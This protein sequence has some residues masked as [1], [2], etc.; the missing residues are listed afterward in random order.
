MGSCYRW[1]GTDTGRR[2]D[3]AMRR[4]GRSLGGVNNATTPETSGQRRPG[5]GCVPVP[6]P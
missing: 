6:P 2:G 5:V 4:V 3:A 1:V